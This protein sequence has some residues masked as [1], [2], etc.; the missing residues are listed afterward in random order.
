MKTLMQTISP[1]RLL[2]LVVAL[3]LMVTGHGVR[4]ED[5]VER[6]LVAAT[7]QWDAAFNSGDAGSVTGLY[8][9]DAILVPP[10]SEV[11]RGHDDIQAFWAGLIEEPA[12]VT[13]DNVGST[14][15]TI[16]VPESSC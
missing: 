1:G 5:S 10:G 2:T 4:A 7:A 9:D 6:A 14:L 11:V 13:Q 3:A 15:V 16:L 8:A 12:H